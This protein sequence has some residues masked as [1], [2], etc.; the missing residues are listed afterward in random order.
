ME[1]V[2][3]TDSFWWTWVILP[4]LIFISRILDQ[5]IGTLRVIFVSKGLK[6]IAP[7]FGFFEVI[8]WLLAVAQVMKHLSN[9]MSYIAYGAG[10]AM[11]NYIGIL[12]EEKLSLGTLLVRIIP[13][14]DTTELIKHLKQEGFGITQVD[15]TGAMGSNVKILFTI[16]KRKN[17][18]KVIHAINQYNPNA[19][20]TLE[21][22]KAVKEG[23]FGIPIQPKGIGIREGIFK[24]K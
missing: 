12:I 19:F 6:N 16:I 11:G 4:L 10:F 20:Y 5:S 18:H 17:V 15:A 3:F 8:I 1:N 14:A 13:K 7:F 22:V 24:R 9:P 21:E 23:Y 2:L